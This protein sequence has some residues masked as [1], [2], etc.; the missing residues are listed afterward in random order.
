MSPCILPRRANNLCAYLWGA[1]RLTKLFYC[2]LRQ[3][4]TFWG[5]IILSAEQN[6]FIHW[7]CRAHNLCAY[8][9]GASRLTKLFYCWLRQNRAFWGIINV[10][11]RF[12]LTRSTR[13]SLPH[14]SKRRCSL[15]L[16]S[17]VAMFKLTVTHSENTWRASKT[18]AKYKWTYRGKSLL[19]GYRDAGTWLGRGS[20]DT[21]KSWY[22]A[23]H[24]SHAMKQ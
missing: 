22:T 9:W 16:I 1:S 7:L 17:S 15:R 24:K 18:N 11:M 3:N 14:F 4:R 6:A 23:T 8:L 2:W 20:I 13:H 19:A 12:Y 21:M 10:W 5:I